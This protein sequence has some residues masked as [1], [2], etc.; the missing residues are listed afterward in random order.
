LFGED[1]RETAVMQVQSNVKGTD[2]VQGQFGLTTKE[3]FAPGRSMYVAGPQTP[4]Q[5]TTPVTAQQA[6]ASMQ[7]GPAQH[8]TPGVSN[9]APVQPTT[10]KD[11]DNA[12]TR[13]TKKSSNRMS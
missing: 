2:V 13:R 8:L 6:W 4:E 9:A 5:A 12:Q 10:W 1:A 7:Q 3:P 11:P